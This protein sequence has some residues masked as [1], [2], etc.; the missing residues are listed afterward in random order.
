[1]TNSASTLAAAHEGPIDALVTDL[2]MPGMSGHALAARLTQSRPTLRVLVLSGNPAAQGT[3][4]GSAWPLL[5]KPFTAQALLA[6]VRQVL[7][8]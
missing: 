1:L 4:G 3:A 6:R 5:R 2:Q 7:D 8:S